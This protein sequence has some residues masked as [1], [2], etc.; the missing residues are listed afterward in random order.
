MRLSFLVHYSSIRAFHDHSCF[1]AVLLYT[2]KGVHTAGHTRNVNG[3]LRCVC[4]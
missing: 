2:H 4:S 3:A 1:S